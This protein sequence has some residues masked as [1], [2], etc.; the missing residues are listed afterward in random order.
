M[1]QEIV[2]RSAKIFIFVDVSTEKKR[3]KR[4]NV[5][6]EPSTEGDSNLYLTASRYPFLF[7][8]EGKDTL[9][10]K[11]PEGDLGHFPGKRPLI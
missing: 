11:S 5:R 3:K 9:V 7:G 2:R 8:Y 1:K 10:E 6:R 4:D